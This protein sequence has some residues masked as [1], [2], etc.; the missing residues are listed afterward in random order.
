MVLD[1][2]DGHQRHACHF[3]LPVLVSNCDILLQ[4]LEGI[5][6]PKHKMCSEV[7]FNVKVQ[8]QWSSLPGQFFLQLYLYKSP[9]GSRAVSIKQVVLRAPPLRRPAGFQRD[10]LAAVRSAETCSDGEQGSLVSD[11]A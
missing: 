4:I 6:P 9:T 5:Q 1:T 7:I 8:L 10:L 11:K 3:Y 2:Q